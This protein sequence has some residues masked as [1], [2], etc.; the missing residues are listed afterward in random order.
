MQ[1]VKRNMTFGQNGGSL[2]GGCF[3]KVFS[4]SLLFAHLIW[5]AIIKVFIST[6][7]VEWFFYQRFIHTTSMTE[8]I[9][10]HLFRLIYWTTNL[11][12]YSR[13]KLNMGFCDSYTKCEIKKSGTGV[14][15]LKTLTGEISNKS[16]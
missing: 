6:Q 1:L 3:F 16:H 11:C 13:G 5:L 8:Q 2:R 4:S 12:L 7:S 9:L 15:G 10:S 14:K